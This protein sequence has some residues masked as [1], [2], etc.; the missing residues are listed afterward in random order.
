MALS[1][2][3]FH[4]DFPIL[5]ELL[6]QLIRNPIEFFGIDLSRIEIDKLENILKPCYI[7]YA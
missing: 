5:N 2:I 7:S 3:K 6:Q 4:V 1:N